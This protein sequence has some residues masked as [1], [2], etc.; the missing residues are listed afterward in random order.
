MKYSKENIKI[1]NVYNQTIDINLYHLVLNDFSELYEDI[2]KEISN[3][4]DSSIGYSVDET[5]KLIF[6][7]FSSKTNNQKHGLCAE[8]F[9]H[10][11]L[12]DLGYKQ[13]SLFS[14]LEEK[15]MKK[16]FDGLYELS[17]DFWIAES[18]CSIK[19]N[20]H[21]NKINE[22]LND[23]DKKFNGTS[24]NDPWQNAIHHLIVSRKDES[25]DS[26]YKKLSNL[27]KEYANDIYHDSSEFNLIPTSTLFVN[28]DQSVSEIK[29]DIENLLSLRKIKNMIVLCIDNN[30]YDAFIS[31][32]KGE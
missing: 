6:N 2:N 8:F 29:K 16:G 11:L 14:N 20:K 18:K 7:L 27:T 3:I 1:T 5:K 9:M 17:D 23:M 4:Y 22:A 28:N 12:R 19:E 15:L 32:L 21:K 13:Y 26:L 25:C 31:Y 24:K 10:L 30:V